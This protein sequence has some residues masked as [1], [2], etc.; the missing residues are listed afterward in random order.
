MQRSLTM[1]MFS[2]YSEVN[3]GIAY[4]YDGVLC[5]F[6]INCSRNCNISSSKIIYRAFILIDEYFEKV[7]YDDPPDLSNSHDTFI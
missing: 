7:S 4:N 6:Y 3:L 1:I 5:I 2:G